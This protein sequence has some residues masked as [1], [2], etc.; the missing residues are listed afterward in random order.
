MND[1]SQKSEFWQREFF[2]II[3]HVVKPI[4]DELQ[5]PS[6][7]KFYKNSVDRGDFMWIHSGQMM[8]NLMTSFLSKQKPFF[9]LCF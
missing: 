6:L 1:L 8:K 2:N 3:R 4:Y 7:S 9:K 5:K